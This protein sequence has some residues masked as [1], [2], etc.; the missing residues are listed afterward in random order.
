MGETKGQEFRVYRIVL[1]DGH[2]PLREGLKRILEEGVG[3]EVVGEAEDGVELLRLLKQFAPHLVILD[4]SMP[5]GDGF[6]VT[7]TIKRLYPGIKVLILTM[8]RSYEYLR[9]ALSAGADGYSL[10]ED[11]TTEILAALE[12][13][14]RGGIYISPLLTREPG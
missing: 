8:H 13:I 10:K 11:A 1:A 14:R 7:R 3:L 6:E 5:E 12:V 9:H 4:V 2:I